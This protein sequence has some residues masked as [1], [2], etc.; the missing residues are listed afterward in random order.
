MNDKKFKNYSISNND[1]YY[2][3]FSPKTKLEGADPATFTVFDKSKF[4]YRY[5]T[6]LAADKSGF[7]L[8]DQKIPFENAHQVRILAPYSNGYCMYLFSHKS[9]LFRINSNDKRVDAVKNS[10]GDFIAIPTNKDNISSHYFKKSDA[11]CF[12]DIHT[13]QM[14]KLEDANPKTFHGYSQRYGFN[15]FWGKDDKFVYSEGSKIKDAD[16]K[17]FKYAGWIYAKDINRVYVLGRKWTVIK[18]A[19]PSTFEVVKGR[20]I[21]AVDKKYAYNN[22]HIVN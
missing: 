4:N 7:Y 6:E 18:E 13:N 16:I 3:R 11:V 5:L 21:D 15:L 20:G 12:Y 1:V 8:Y 10:G 14:I 19:D 22:G 9:K 17:T 2:V